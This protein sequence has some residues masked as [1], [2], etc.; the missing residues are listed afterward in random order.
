M[1][2]E[3]K[4]R[5]GISG[6]DLSAWGTTTGSTTASVDTSGVLR[7]TNP[8]EQDKFQ[9][10]EAISEM[11]MPDGGVH[12][13]TVSKGAIKNTI[14]GLAE[15]ENE[16]LKKSGEKLQL[17]VYAQAF[18]ENQSFLGYSGDYEPLEDTRASYSDLTRRGLRR[19]QAQV[20]RSFAGAQFT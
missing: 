15:N 14:R 18:Y 10:D 7:V 17:L 16:E 8:E 19:L 13:S 11:L 4:K 9:S 1:Q 2:E 12:V 5:F 6:V 3:L 20:L